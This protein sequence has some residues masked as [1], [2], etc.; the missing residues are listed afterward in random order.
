[1]ITPLFITNQTILVICSLAPIN[2]FIMGNGYHSTTAGIYD[3]NAISYAQYTLYI[4]PLYDKI[5][6]MV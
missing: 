6:L 2:L 4:S 1:M 5:F 3:I